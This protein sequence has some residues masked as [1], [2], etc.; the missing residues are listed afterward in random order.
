MSDKNSAVAVY[1]SHVA[2]EQAIQDLQR[3]GFDMKKL[4]IVGKDFHRDEHVVGYYTAG[5]RMRYWGKAG[6]FWGGIFGLLFGSA[7]FWIPGIGPL[8]AAGPVVAW[9]VGRW[10]KR[11]W[12]G[13]SAR[14]GPGSTALESTKT[15]S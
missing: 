3:S 1:D 4:S 8:V 10:R 7:L 13:R 11:P 12:S 6:A 14:L 2:A 5:D 15:A 9:I